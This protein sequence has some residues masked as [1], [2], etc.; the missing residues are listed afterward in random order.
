MLYFYF[1]LFLLLSLPNPVCI[2][3]TLT[4]HLN[5]FTNFYMVEA[6]WSPTKTKLCL[7]EKY[8]TLCPLKSKCLIK[9]K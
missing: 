1:I 2:L 8:F 6:K 7:M 4:A 5:S 9:M 3:I